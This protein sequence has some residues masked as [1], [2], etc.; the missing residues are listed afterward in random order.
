MHSVH[1][2]SGNA[3]D[4]GDH[5][6]DLTVHKHLD[7]D[8]F[9]QF[10]EAYQ[11]VRQ[12]GARLVADAGCGYG[13]FAVFVASQAPAIQVDGYT[14][15][16]VQQAVAQQVLTRL[17]MPQ[18]RVLLQSYDR[19]VRQY[20]AIVAIESLGH[21][22]HVGATLQHWAGHL[23]PGGV[24]VIIDEV[25]RPEVVP[26]HPEIQQFLQYW[27]FP[28]LLQRTRVEALVQ[29]AGLHMAAWDILSERYHVHTRSDDEC[30]RLLHT[31]QH[32]DAHP[33][34]IG[35]MFLEKFYNRGWVDYVLMV[36]TP[37][38]AASRGGAAAV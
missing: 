31:Y 20:D 23:Q 9:I 33:G 36:L 24:V 32:Q 6:H 22:S 12:A 18:A 16:D 15:S 14:L 34:Y 26:E 19:L 5:L 25:F 21:A 11:W 7:Q 8:P 10:R 30:D 3:Y 13:G 28:L 29:A 2:Q 1:T 17:H 37:H 27:H 35:G 38:D 4:M